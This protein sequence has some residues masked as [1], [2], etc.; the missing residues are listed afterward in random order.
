[1][2]GRNA[3]ATVFELNSSHPPSTSFVFG[4]NL[5]SGVVVDA[6]LPLLSDHFSM[7]LVHH[8]EV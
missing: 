3:W 8:S 5:L 7:F 1:M 4:A 6:H 2:T